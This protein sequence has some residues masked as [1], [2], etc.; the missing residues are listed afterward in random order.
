M[1]KPS[2]FCKGCGPGALGVPLPHQSGTNQGRGLV[3]S[4][5]EVAPLLKRSHLLP[6]QLK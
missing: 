5:M 2:M 3:G 4:F 1:G 6:Q